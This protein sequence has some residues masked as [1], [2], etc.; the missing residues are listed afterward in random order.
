[1]KNSKTSFWNDFLREAL[2]EER[3]LYF[4]LQTVISVTILEYFLFIIFSKQESSRFQN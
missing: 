4:H 1:M 3:I 2:R